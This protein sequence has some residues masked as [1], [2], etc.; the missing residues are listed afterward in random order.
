MK[1]YT[2]F[3]C[4]KK[5]CHISSPYYMFTHTSDVSDVGNAGKW[6]INLTER[7]F[8]ELIGHIDQGGK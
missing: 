6:R 2:H 5:Y 7:N 3:C 1:K 4:G 8:Y